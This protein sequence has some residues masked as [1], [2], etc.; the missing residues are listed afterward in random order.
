[1]TGNSQ[2]RRLLVVNPNTSKA[3][4]HVI[5]A[6]VNNTLQA[7][8]GIVEATTVHVDHGVESVE[9]SFDEVV[10]AYWTLEK[11]VPLLPSYDGVLVACFSNHVAVKAL[12]EYTSKPVMHIM[13][14][15]ILQ[16]LPLG[17]H[18]SIITDS[19]HWCP[20][21]EEGVQ[22]VLGSL[23][24]CASVR[25]AEMTA[26]DTVTLSQDQ[27]VEK[28]ASAGRQ[29]IDQDGA[30]VLILG[31][32]G[33]A[34]TRERMVT[35]LGVPIIDAVAAGVNTMIGPMITQLTTSPVGMYTPLPPRPEE[36][37]VPNPGIMTAYQADPKNQ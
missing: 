1:M 15:A 29:A 37:N 16:S 28:L 3:M 27:V 34:H 31:C 21:L 12:R 14:A 23:E 25:S 22:S 20:L 26:L 24:R 10:S 11:V 2:V 4:T 19:G 8:G 36:V 9:G 7:Y 5:T 30:E 18:F 32:A 13:E 17:A 35:L 6:S 33:L